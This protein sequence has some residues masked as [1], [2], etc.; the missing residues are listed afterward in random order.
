MHSFSPCT[1]NFLF[2]QLPDDSSHPGVGTEAG[3]SN[4]FTIHRHGQPRVGKNDR[5]LDAPVGSCV[6]QRYP[7]GNV[8]VRLLECVRRKEGLSHAVDVAV[9]E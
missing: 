9:R 8:A 2:E 5:E 7:D 1:I 6:V 4:E 3:V